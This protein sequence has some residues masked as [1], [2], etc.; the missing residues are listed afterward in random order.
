MQRTITLSSF[1]LAVGAA[2]LWSAAPLRAAAAADAPA[3]D[4]PADAIPD[5]AT[6]EKR[7]ADLMTNATLVGRFTTHGKEDAPAKEDRYT[8]LKA[9]KADGDNWVITAKMGPVPVDLTLPVRWA[10]D[11]PMIQMTNQKIVMGTFTVRIMFYGNHYAG[12]WDAGDHGG[13]MW[14]RIEH[15]DAGAKPKSGAAPKPDEKPAAEK[16]K[17]PAPK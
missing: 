4:K 9:V 17:D 13:L 1:V 12:T 11:T 15:G 7:F 10:G 16:S 14:G 3:S 2:L 6:L 8:I 5:R